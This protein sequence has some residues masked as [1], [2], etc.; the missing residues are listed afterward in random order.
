MMVLRYV[1]TH[2][3]FLVKA[4]ACA[5]MFVLSRVAVCVA[6]V[7]TASLKCANV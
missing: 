7:I 4:V 5:C 3:H 1:N 2:S 6:A